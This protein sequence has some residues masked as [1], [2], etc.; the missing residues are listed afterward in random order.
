[1]PVPPATVVE[2]LPLDVLLHVGFTADAVTLRIA[3]LASVADPD[4]VQPTELETVTL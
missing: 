4:A 2:I 1:M 3:G